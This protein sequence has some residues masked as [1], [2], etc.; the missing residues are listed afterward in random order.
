MV[1]ISNGFSSQPAELSGINTMFYSLYD[2]AVHEIRTT[3]RDFEDPKSEIPDATMIHYMM[4][5]N[6]IVEQI[7]EKEFEI[8]EMRESKKKY[9][10]KYQHLFRDGELYRYADIR[11]TCKRNFEIAEFQIKSSLYEAWLAGYIRRFVSGL[12][13][14]TSANPERYGRGMFHG[15]YYIFE[16]RRKAEEVGYDIVDR[17]FRFI[18]ELH[19]RYPPGKFPRA[20]QSEYTAGRKSRGNSRVPKRVRKRN[21]QSKQARETRVNR[22][23][24]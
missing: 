17:D 8:E 21:K 7:P 16:P 18:R 1:R 5:G 9:F 6:G 12:Y 11:E 13:W 24:K 14:S 15:I 3:I 19:T 23:G 4:N 20:S 10:D 2:R 22:N